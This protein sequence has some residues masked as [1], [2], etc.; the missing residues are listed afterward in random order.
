M[1]S[2]EVSGFPSHSEA[3]AAFLFPLLC[4]SVHPES[5]LSLSQIPS[6][7][8]CGGLILNLQSPTQ[9]PFCPRETLLSPPSVSRTSLLPALFIPGLHGSCH[10]G[11]VCCYV[12][13]GL[14]SLGGL[15]SLGT[16][17]LPSLNLQY[18]VELWFTVVS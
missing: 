2:R 14:C 10:R 9:I 16:M 15:W 7:F 8:L 1:A 13:E 18:S 3:A 5:S 17:P 12:W 4:S 11:I 6:L